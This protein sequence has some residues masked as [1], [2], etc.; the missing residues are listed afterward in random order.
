[1]TPLH[2][3]ARDGH[4]EIVDY[5]A[6]NNANINSMDNDC[7]CFDIKI[8]HFIML[9]NMDTLMLLRRFLITMLA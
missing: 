7:D 1:M 9:L 5:L 6:K 4:L 3:A 8:H 2:F